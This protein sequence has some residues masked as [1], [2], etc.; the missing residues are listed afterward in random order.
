MKVLKQPLIP[1]LL[2]TCVCVLFG[3]YMSHQP[4]SPEG[5]YEY[6]PMICIKDEIYGDNG[7]GVKALP[8]GYVSVGQIEEKVSN[9]QPMI[10]RNYVSNTLNVGT[11][12]FASQDNPDKIYLKIDNS[13]YIE[14]I[15]LPEAYSE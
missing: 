15:R 8:E 3:F 13:K 9:V 7:T 6:R 14:Y 10:K 5:K 12:I 2:T 4:V 11:E 1:L